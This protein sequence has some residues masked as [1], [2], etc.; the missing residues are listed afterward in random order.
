MLGTLGYVDDTRAY[1]LTLLCLCRSLVRA[2]A[3]SLLSSPGSAIIQMVV[4]HHRNLV[5]TLA[6]NG[7]IEGFDLGQSGEKFASFGRV[8]ISCVALACSDIG[9]KADTAPCWDITETSA[10]ATRR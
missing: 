7:T 8:T 3:G 5:Y 10:R 4:D 9:V 6:E 1:G 2:I